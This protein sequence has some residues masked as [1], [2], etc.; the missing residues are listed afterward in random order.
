MQK[1][2][3]L[4]VIVLL[5]FATIRIVF[6]DAPNTEHFI[7]L[8]MAWFCMIILFIKYKRLTKDEY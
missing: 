4:I 6:M 1:D 2:L 5:I 7:G 8:G 3:F